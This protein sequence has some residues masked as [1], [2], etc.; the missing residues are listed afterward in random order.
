MD[1]TIQHGVFVIFT[2]VTLGSAL[3]VVTVRN[4]FHAAL[5]LM[6]CLFGVAGLF[7]L[8]TA[9]LLAGFQV[10]IY[11]GAIAIL[12]IFAIMLTPQVTRV[13]KTTNAQWPVA[14]VVAVL[15]FVMILSVVSPLMD[16]LGVDDWNADFTQEDADRVPD[17]TLTDFGES[18]VSRDRFVLPFEIASIMLMA[19]LIGA[20]LVVSPDAILRRDESQPPP[21]DT[22]VSA[23]TG[24]SG[25]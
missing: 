16:E 6:L 20:V 25:D 12:I 11:I 5:Y 13:I 9:P 7:A 15:F 18:L 14:I 24:A 2:L 22:S 10:V 8:L 19:A 3:L 1:I 17:S 4:L 21:S 23:D